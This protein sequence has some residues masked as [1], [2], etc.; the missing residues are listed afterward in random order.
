MSVDDFLLQKL[1]AGSRAATSPRQIIAPPNGVP[2]GP[3]LIVKDATDMTPESTRFHLRP[4][5]FAGEANWLEGPPKNGKTMVTCAFV[6][7]TTNGNPFFNNEYARTGNVL[8]LT[9]EDKP[10]RTILPR[11]IAAGARTEHVRFIVG[12]TD[13]SGEGERGITLPDNIDLLEGEIRDYGAVLLVIDGTFGFTRADDKGSY[14]DAYRFVRPLAE[15]ARRTDAAVILMRHTRKSEGSAIDK[16]I[17]SIGYAALGRSTLTVAMDREDET[18]ARRI[19][20]HVGANNGETGQSIAFTIETV[21]IPGL[22]EPVGRAVWQ[23]FV[24]ISAD[25]VVSYRPIDDEAD[26]TVA[27]EFLLDLLR[28]GL[29]HKTADVFE[30]GDRKR[31]NRRTLQRAGKHLRIVMERR[32]EFAGGSTWRLPPHVHDAESI[33]DTFATRSLS[34]ANGANEV[35]R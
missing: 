5:L 9:C 21:N 35:T 17:G 25:E 27:E 10:E 6:A 23:E 8:Y 16:G 4:Y 19:L 28:D 30:A 14:T 7:L 12:R 34:V 18:G 29:E 15:M 33:S 2:I 24:R 26:R 20:A 13:D 32:R 31:I 11:L 22:E 1:A 3:R